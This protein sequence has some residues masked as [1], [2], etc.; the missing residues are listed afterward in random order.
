MPPNYLVLCIKS[1]LVKLR[2]RETLENPGDPWDANPVIAGRFGVMG[3][4]QHGFSEY[5]LTTANKQTKWEKFLS[6]MELVVP[7]QELI[8]LIEPCY[9]KTSKNGVRPSYPLATMLRNDYG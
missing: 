4:K 8:D 3:G 5:E 7:W 1:T 9:P 2:L 6:E